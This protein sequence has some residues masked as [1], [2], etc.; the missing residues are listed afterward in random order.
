MHLQRGEKH[1][2]FHVWRNERFLAIQNMV[3]DES[4]HLLFAMWTVLMDQMAGVYVKK[5]E[6]EPEWTG[7]VTCS[8]ENILGGNEIHKNPKLY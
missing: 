6:T 8:M 1:P 3:I 5:R 7:T 4:D 2:H